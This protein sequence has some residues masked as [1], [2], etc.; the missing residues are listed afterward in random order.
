MR[1]DDC[2]FDNFSGDNASFK[3]KVKITGK[4]S[5]DGN[6][7]D[8]KIELPLMYLSNIWKTLKMPLINCEINLILIWSLTCVITNS[9]GKRAFT[10]R[11]KKTLCYSC[12]FINS[13]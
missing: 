2:D 8:A 7:K 4:S 9:I 6:T 3:V 1:D 11:D 5:A 10:I 13:R 12:N